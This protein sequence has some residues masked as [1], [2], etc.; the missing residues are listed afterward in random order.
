MESSPYDEAYPV[1]DDDEPSG[2]EMYTPSPRQQGASNLHN[3]SQGCAFC[4]LW[5]A[6]FSD[7]LKNIESFN[8]THIVDL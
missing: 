1:D 2:V 4:D 6:R 3:Q 8:G 5:K 7:N